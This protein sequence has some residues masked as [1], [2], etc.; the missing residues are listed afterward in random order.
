[1][2]ADEIHHMTAEQLRDFNVKVDERMP[3]DRIA[4]VSTAKGAEPVIIINADPV[5]NILEKRKQDR[6]RG[7]R[8]KRDP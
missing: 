5:A 8:C 7:E 4:V 3:R 1:M 2:A 6:E